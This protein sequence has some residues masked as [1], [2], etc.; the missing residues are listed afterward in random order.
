MPRLGAL[1]DRFRNRQLSDS[2]A[3]E[4]AT[5]ALLLRYDS[6][7]QSPVDART[8]LAPRRAEDQGSDLWATFNCLQ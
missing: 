2:E 3:L 7:E 8:L 4:F 5:N 6:L 1:I